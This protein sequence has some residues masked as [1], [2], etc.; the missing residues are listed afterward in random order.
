MLIETTINAQTKNYLKAEELAIIIKAMRLPSEWTGQVYNFFADVP[1]QDIDNFSAL[2]GI[3]DIALKRYY[4]K[5][6]KNVYPN[7]ELEE[8]LRYA[9]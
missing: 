6:I 8:M 2:F 4:D 7:Q 9:Q 5:Y 3:A 1:V